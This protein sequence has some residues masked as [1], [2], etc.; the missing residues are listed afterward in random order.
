[1]KKKF[2]KETIEIHDISI[3]FVFGGKFY[4]HRRL[5]CFAK[6]GCACV[7]CGL[8]GTELRTERWHDGSLH[9]DLYAFNAQ[10]HQVLM[11]VDH[12]WPRS[13]GGPS[14]IENYQPMCAPCNERKGN[15]TVATKPNV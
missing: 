12:I 7:G 13:K 2:I 9:H 11:T 14:V 3:V 10:G 15:K 5:Q 1:M 4:D 8:V 6:K